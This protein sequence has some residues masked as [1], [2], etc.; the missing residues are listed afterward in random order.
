[1]KHKMGA[2]FYQFS[3]FHEHR[4]VIY[5]QSINKSDTEL[6]SYC[7]PLGLCRIG[8]S[9]YY[10]CTSTLHFTNIYKRLQIKCS[11]LEI[12]Y[13]KVFAENSISV[14]YIQTFWARYITSKCLV[15]RFHTFY[16]YFHCFIC[17][18]ILHNY[19]R[20]QLSL[21]DKSLYIDR[22][23]TVTTDYGY[24]SIILVLISYYISGP[25]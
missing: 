13:Y 11:R 14:Y 9:S 24:G 23:L 19:S 4:F 15:Y 21:D 12:I 25:F 8:W 10:L 22:S 16:C 2:I 18:F 6:K 17:T 1:M 20:V 5:D 7:I 3:L